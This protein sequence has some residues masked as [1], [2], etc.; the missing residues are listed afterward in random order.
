M[1]R[2]FL[3]VSL[4]LALGC[5]PATTLGS[6]RVKQPITGPYEISNPSIKVKLLPPAPPYPRDAKIAGIKGDVTLN[7]T[8]D[9]NGIPISVKAAAGPFEL[10]PTATFYVQKV[11]F[12][13]FFE[14]GLPIETSF[15]FVL[16]FR[17]R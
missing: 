9:K 7:V 17:L 5:A 15:Q 12:F 8:I 4:A 2:L 14:N 10:R 1:H 11:E 3:Y 13:P 6:N 16:P